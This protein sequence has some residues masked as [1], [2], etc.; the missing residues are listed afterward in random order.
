[1]LSK[2][3]ADFIRGE[4][5]CFIRIGRDSR[6][7]ARVQKTIERILI[8]DHAALTTV[9]IYIEARDDAGE[10]REMWMLETDNEQL[11]RLDQFLRRFSVE[12][13]RL[14]ESLMST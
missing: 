10:L 6:A 3:K 14:I 1:M 13:V 9:S 12:D 5:E 7:R 8:S 2:E 4:F 11:A